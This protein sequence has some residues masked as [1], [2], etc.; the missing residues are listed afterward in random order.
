MAKASE[1]TRE[2]RE[3]LER[4]PRIE[5]EPDYCECCGEHVNEHTEDEL[6]GCIDAMQ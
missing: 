6:R 3:L 4:L 1:E 5:G 2:A